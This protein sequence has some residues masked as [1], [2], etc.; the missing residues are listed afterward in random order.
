M[1]FR[2]ITKNRWRAVGVGYGR[3]YRLDD[4][5]IVRNRCERDD[6]NVRKFKAPTMLNRIELGIFESESGKSP[7]RCSM[8]C[9][10]LC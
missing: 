1:D 7:H 10:S 8:K 5:H 9:P 4:N 2:E 6:I 3:V